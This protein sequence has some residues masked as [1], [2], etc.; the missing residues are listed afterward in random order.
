MVTTIKAMIWI[1]LITVFDMVDPVDSAV[2]YIPDQERK[3]YCG[4]HL[5]EHGEIDPELAGIYRL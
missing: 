2:G 5:P 4:R 3:Y 1:T